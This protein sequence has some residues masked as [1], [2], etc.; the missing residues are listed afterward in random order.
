MSRSEKLRS[1]VQEGADRYN[2]TA[3]HFDIDALPPLLARHL[4]PGPLALADFGCGDG[5]WFSLLS[6]RG[7]ISAKRPVCA[8]DL[9]AQRLERVVS[10]FPFVSPYVAPADAVPDIASESLDF[11]ISTMVMEHVPD[12]ARYLDEVRRVLRPGGKAYL[13]T[14][15]KKPWAWYFRKRKG[16]SVL[17]KSHLREYTDLELFESL[18]MRDGRFRSLLALE[19]EP[20]WFS[21]L[22]PVLFRLAPHAGGYMHS[23]VLKALRAPKVRIPGYYSLGVVVER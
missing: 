18:L 20:L 13:T 12:E 21:V 7:Y 4:P 5:P 22:D 15:F 1:E 10:R 17:D 19:L 8:V 11:V 3:L 23:S 6:Q 9:E 2:A 16:E 14:V